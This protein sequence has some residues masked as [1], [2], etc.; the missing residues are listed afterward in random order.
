MRW[1]YDIMMSAGVVSLF[2]WIQMHT[3]SMDRGSIKHS[4]N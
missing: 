1:Y 4:M 3:L 2:F